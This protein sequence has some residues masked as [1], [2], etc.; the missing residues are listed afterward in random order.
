MFDLEQAIADWRQQMLAVGI[1]TPV[2]LEELET[3]LRE[4]VAGQK[5]TGVSEPVAFA[6]AV[7]RIGRAEDLKLEFA[8]SRGEIKRRY[9]LLAQV[10]LAYSLLAFGAMKLMGIR[11][12]LKTE[13]SPAWRLAGWTDIAVFALIV[14]GLL[15]WRWSRRAFP[16]IPSRRARRVVGIG[17]CLVAGAALVALRDFILPDSEFAQGAEL[18]MILWYFT[19]A[20]A[21]AVLLAGLEAAAQ[22][23]TH[24]LKYVRS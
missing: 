12:F 3:H 11:A 18:V 23:Q 6:A 16:R 5:K 15:G 24:D 1:K 2:P 19:L 22:I 14:A 17:F 7:Q 10:V 9:Q 4:D 8:N 13:M 20:F 21:L